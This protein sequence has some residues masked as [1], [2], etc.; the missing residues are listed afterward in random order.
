MHG[1]KLNPQPIPGDIVTFSYQYYTK[2]LAPVN[3]KIERIRRD[4]SWAEI[5]HDFSSNI[6]QPQTLNGTWSLGSYYLFL[7]LYNSATLPLK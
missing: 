5:L 3:P 7:Y 1:D 2:L 4:V 6:L